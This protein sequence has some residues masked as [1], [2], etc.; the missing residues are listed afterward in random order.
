MKSGWS[1]LN[2]RPSDVVL[3]EMPSIARSFARC[4]RTNDGDKVLAYL[5]K[6]TKGRVLT[7]AAGD[8]EL[9]F[10]EGQRALVAHME[11]LIERGRGSAVS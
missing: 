11:T 7:A 3:D 8:A 1:F 9:R 10:L 6:M 4:F 2:D 5:Q